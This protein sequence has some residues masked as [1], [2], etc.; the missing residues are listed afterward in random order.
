MELLLL[1]EYH[2]QEQVPKKLHLAMHHSQLLPSNIHCQY[3]KSHPLQNQKIQQIHQYLEYHHLHLQCIRSYHSM[4]HQM[5]HAYQLIIDLHILGIHM[6]THK[7][8]HQYLHLSQSL[9]R[10]YQYI[11]SIY[12]NHHQSLLMGRSYQLKDQYIQDLEMQ[13]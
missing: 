5:S 6:Y 2:H 1:K 12:K 10:Q 8:H 4:N 9:L 7:N 3:I 11:H 13:K